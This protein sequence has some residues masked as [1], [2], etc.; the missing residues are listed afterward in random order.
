[1]RK[2][3][4]PVLLALLT[5]CSQ[6]AQRP[7][8]PAQPVASESDCL[9]RGGQWMQLGRAQVKQCLLRTNDAGKACSD[10]AQCEGLCLAPEGSQDGAAVGGTCAVDTNKFGCQQRLRDGVAVTMCVD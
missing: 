3:V 9:Q 10:S 4:V 8:D 6:P 1:M 2:F 5:A 7:S